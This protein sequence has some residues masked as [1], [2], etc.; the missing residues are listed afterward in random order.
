MA[1]KRANVKDIISWFDLD[2]YDYVLELPVKHVL[3]E[4]FFRHGIHETFLNRAMR[5]EFPVF[6]RIDILEDDHYFDGVHYNDRGIL[7]LNHDFIAKM[8]NSGVKR[9]IYKISEGKVFVNEPWFGKTASYA[10]V[11][12]Y[13]CLEEVPESCDPNEAFNIGLILDL[14]LDLMTDEEITNHIAYNLPKWRKR[15][16][17]PEPKYVGEGQ[18]IGGAFIRKIYDYKIIPFLDLQMWAAANKVEITNDLYSRLLFP[19]GVD[20]LKSDS[21]IRNTIKPF[22]DSV[23]DVIYK[24][25]LSLFLAKNPHIEDMLFS[26]FLKLA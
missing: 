24:P 17:V 19:L 3:A 22:A 5:G 13:D 20:K 25:E 15:F 10:E 21:N 16:S 2:K 7:P 9:N 12:C 18:K 11:D 6:D 1:K 26:D 4:V 14:S 8:V 23:L